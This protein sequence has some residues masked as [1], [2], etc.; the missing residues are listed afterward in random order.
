[1]FA[2]NMHLE[3]SERAECRRSQPISELGEGHAKYTEQPLS[4]CRVGNDREEPVCETKE[5]GTRGTRVLEL[6]QN[7][8]WVWLF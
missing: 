5:G 7:N 4:C 8:Q 6:L 2:P 1:M 3:L